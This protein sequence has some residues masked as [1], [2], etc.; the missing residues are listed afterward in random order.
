MISLKVNGKTLEI[1]QGSH[2]YFATDD[3][4]AFYQEWDC[5]AA[6]EIRS[7]FSQLEEMAATVMEKMA[8]A[9]SSLKSGPGRGTTDRTIN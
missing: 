8:R 3:G 1:V 9:T 7:A 5:I 6:E 4:A 2:I